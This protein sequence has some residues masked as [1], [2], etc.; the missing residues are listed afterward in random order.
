MIVNQRDEKG[1]RML[2]LK[3]FKF[4]EISKQLKV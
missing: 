2:D 4:I 1:L 3:E